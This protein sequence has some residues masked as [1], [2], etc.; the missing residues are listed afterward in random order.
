[1]E[2]VPVVQRQPPPV[3][4]QAFTLGVRRAEVVSDQ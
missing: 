4:H 3:N 1:M 2:C